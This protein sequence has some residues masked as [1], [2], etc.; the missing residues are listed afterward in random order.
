[1][2][3]QSTSLTTA[4]S[5]TDPYA[6]SPTGLRPIVVT[7]DSDN[8]VDIIVLGDGYTASEIEAAFT[9]DVLEYLSYIFDDS[10]LTQPLGRYENFFNIYAVD[11]VSN[12]SGAD[13]PGLG[14]VRDTALG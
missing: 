3:P 4:I 11:V 13:N 12:E 6:V 7:G 1:M 14:I 2:N 9:A 10:A 8:R 5:A